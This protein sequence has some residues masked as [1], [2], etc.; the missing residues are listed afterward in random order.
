M[1]DSTWVRWSPPWATHVIGAIEPRRWNAEDRRHEPQ[2]VEIVC[3][4][5]GAT[6][7]AL[8]EQGRPLEHVQKFAVAHAHRDPF[9]DE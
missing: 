2:R 7:Q 8:C 3:G 5:C 1:A 6:W 4:V 9:A